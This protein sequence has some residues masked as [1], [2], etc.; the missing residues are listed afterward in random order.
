MLVVYLDDSGTHGASGVV[1]MAGYVARR[2]A[3]QRYEAAARTI[4]FENDVKVF[5]AKDFYHGKKEFA[6]WSYA[7]KRTFANTLFATAKQHFLCGAACSVDKAH[8][9]QTKSAHSILPSTSAYGFCLHL[10]CQKLLRSGAVWSEVQKRGITFLVED[11]NNNNANVIAELNEIKQKNPEVASYLRNVGTVEK[12]SCKAVQIADYLAY[13]SWRLAEKAARGQSLD[14]CPY[15]KTATANVET[16]GGL[17]RDYRP[18][19]SWPHKQRKV[20]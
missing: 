19:P 13:F 17:M 8:F 2:G 1:T 3:W 14:H 5:H 12:A 4:Y 20:R 16:L 15:L 11:G 6:N 9:T 18:N 7:Q 10:V